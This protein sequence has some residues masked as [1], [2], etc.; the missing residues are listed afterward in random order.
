MLEELQGVLAS[1]Q[2]FE[3]YVKTA[4]G[5]PP[6]QFA[7][8][9]HNLDWGAYF[10][11]KDGQR[12]DAHADLCPRTEAALA[13]A[14]QNTLPGRAPVALFSAPKPGTPLPPH[15]RPTNTRLHAHLPLVHPPDCAPPRVPEPRT[16][17]PAPGT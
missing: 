16:R 12:L 6:A 17:A 1:Q 3:P 10:L 11:W 13:P 7:A 2:A 8:L 15:H 4:E 14:P 5:E 9:D